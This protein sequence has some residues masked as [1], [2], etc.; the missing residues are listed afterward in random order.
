MTDDDSSKTTEIAQAIAL[1]ADKRIT[2][3]GTTDDYGVVIFVFDMRTEDMSVV[4]SLPPD[5]PDLHRVIKAYLDSL[6][7]KPS[8]APH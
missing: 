7:T 6:P 2:M 8:G 4:S 3:T 5:H 1:E